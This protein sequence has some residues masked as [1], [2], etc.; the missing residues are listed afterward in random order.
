M[1]LG[2]GRM[3]PNYQKT[4]RCCYWGAALQAL[5]INLAPLFFVTLQ[6]QYAISFEQIGRLV[7]VTFF[8]Q[9]AVDFLSVYTVCRW[10]YRLSLVLA[11][12]FTS[13]GLFLFGILP[14]YMTDAYVGMIVAVFVYSIGAGLLEVLI[15]PM[16]NSL[17]SDRKAEALTFVHSFYPI[18]Q[19]LTIVLT[20][21][22]IRVLGEQYWWLIFMIWAVFPLFNLFRG[23]R[24]PLPETLTESTSG[25]ALKELLKKPMFWLMLLLMMSTGASEMAM[26]QWASTFAEKGLNIDKVWG[27]LLGPLLFAIFMGLGRFCY[28]R[29]RGGVSLKKLLC[30]CAALALLCYGTAAFVPI[31]QIALLGCAVCGLAVSLMWP[32]TLSFCAQRFPQG[33]VA[34][35]SIMALAGDLGCALGPWVTG[36]VSDAVQH[37]FMVDAA[38]GLRSGL[39]VTMIFPLVLFIGLL[40]FKTPKAENRK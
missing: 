36:I 39:A 6:K 9:L 15:S 14:R 25:G 18:G 23:L 38:T 37:R 10:G 40:F 12:A 31:P 35:F 21:V 26:A 11:H 1:D 24:V 34:M 27:D 33:A 8:V 28:G 2:E 32:V 16:A 5:A 17:P 3:E 7:L 20:T 30:S 22:A 4:W 29:S 19:V 13:V